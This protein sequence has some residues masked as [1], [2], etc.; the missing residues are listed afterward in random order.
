MRRAARRAVRWE[1][2]EWRP[3]MGDP[4]VR[5]PPWWMRPSVISVGMVPMVSMV[6]AMC[7]V[8]M[9]PP[10][11]AVLPVRASML[12]RRSAMGT[13][14]R[15][16]VAVELVLAEDLVVELGRD[17]A[18]LVD[19]RLEDALEV[20]ASTDALLDRHAELVG[21][22]P[23]LHRNELLELGGLYAEEFEVLQLDLDLG[24]EVIVL[25]AGPLLRLLLVFRLLLVA[26]VGLRDSHRSGDLGNDDR[27]SLLE[28]CEEADILD[29]LVI[30]HVDVEG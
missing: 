15:P 25:L 12:P 27:C 17:T 13:V 14:M 16:V 8:A 1:V 2:A 10:V 3:P 11:L 21:D 19:D 20:V 26:G 24:F 23:L 7:M 18:H 9:V 5:R 4:M 6:M 30:D 22:E 28:A 29:R